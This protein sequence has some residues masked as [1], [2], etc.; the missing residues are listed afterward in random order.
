MSDV[1]SSEQNLCLIDLAYLMEASDTLMRDRSRSSFSLE[2]SS[3]NLRSLRSA[4]DCFF[5]F[6]VTSVA[7]C[8]GRGHA[9]ELQI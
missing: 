3:C 2:L 5:V 4:M 1:Y 8:V 9:V 7:D 6:C